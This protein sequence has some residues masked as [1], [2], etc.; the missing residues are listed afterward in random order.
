[1]DISYHKSIVLIHDNKQSF[2][3]V[4]GVSNLHLFLRFTSGIWVFFSKRW[5]L[6]VFQYITNWRSTREWDVEE[7]STNEEKLNSIYN[8]CIYLCTFHYDKTLQVSKSQW[9]TTLTYN[10]LNGSNLFNAVS[11]SVVNSTR[12]VLDC[13]TQYQVQLYIL[14][15]WS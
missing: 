11:S 7:P 6:F 2:L 15:G 10:Q 8:T 3:C 5:Y 1:M 12:L 14:P 4:I 13:L 9:I